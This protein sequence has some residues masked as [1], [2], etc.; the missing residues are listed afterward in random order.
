MTIEWVSFLIVFGTALLSAVFV[1][2]LY[3]LGIRFLATPPPPALGPD[4]AA[5]PNGPSR[6]DE[7]DDVEAERPRWA[8]IAANICFGLSVLAVLV[9][10][11]L[12]IPA[13]HFW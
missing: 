6:D 12:I 9:G 1:V 13:L 4:G 3:S 7:D 2:A 10:I 8:T 5:V 11:F